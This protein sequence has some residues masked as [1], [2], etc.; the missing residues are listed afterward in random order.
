MRLKSPRPRM[1]ARGLPKVRTGC[2]TCKIRHK[3]CDESRPACFH[4]SSTGRQCDFILPAQPRHNALGEGYLEDDASVARSIP[5]LFRQPGRSSTPASPLESIHFEFFRLVCAPEYGVYFETPSWESLVLQSVVNE[6]CIYHAALAIGALTWHHYSPMSHWYDPVTR[7]RS[8]VE[9]S[10]IQYNH[11]IRCLNARLGNSAPD[12]DLTK[13]AILSA[14][15]FINIEFFRQESGCPFREGLVA[16]HLHGA[17][18]VL[19]D[20][21]Y[22]FG[23]QP[24]SDR[25]CL[26]MGIIH[27]ERQAEQFEERMI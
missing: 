1:G 10:T 6:P 26:E 4:C 18:C 21:K 25:E 17:T 16:R 14:V 12:K 20:L 24:D 3:K 8:A 11:A 27:I 15:L 23:V 13:L 19:Q 2:R 22:R 9:Y 7:A 5:V